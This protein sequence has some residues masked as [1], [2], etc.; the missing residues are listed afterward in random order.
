MIQGQE[1]GCPG[2]WKMNWSQIAELNVPNN[3]SKGN[4]VCFSIHMAWQDIREKY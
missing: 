1:W 3:G 4:V 2:E